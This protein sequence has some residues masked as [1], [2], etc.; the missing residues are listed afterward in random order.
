MK[1]EMPE[2]ELR[3]VKIMKLSEMIQKAQELKD[4]HGD[5]EILTN[6]GWPLSTFYY[7]KFED[8][9]KE[10]NITAGDEVVEIRICN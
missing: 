1:G 4:K 5:L 2:T 9:N 10:W 6:E 8:D 3:K 7:R